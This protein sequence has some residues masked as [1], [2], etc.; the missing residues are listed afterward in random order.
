MVKIYNNSLLLNIIRKLALTSYGSKAQPFINNHIT[1]GTYL[2]FFSWEERSN[3]DL[4][5]E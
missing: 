5:I 1:L 3:F 2:F 4:P